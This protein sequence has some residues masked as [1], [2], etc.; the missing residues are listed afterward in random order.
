MAVT[1]INDTQGGWVDALATALEESAED[2][3]IVVSN[4]SM[5]EMATRGRDRMG[6]WVRIM[7][8]ETWQELE[9]ASV[10]P[11]KSIKAS[12]RLEKKGE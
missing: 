1:H 9:G 6:K 2:D 5:L 11:S 3:V 10:K 8:E 12:V 4:H 7:T